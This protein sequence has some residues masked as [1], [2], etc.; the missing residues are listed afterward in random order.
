MDNMISRLVGTAA[1]LDCII[2]VGDLEEEPQGRVKK[3]GFHLRTYK[4]QFFLSSVNYLGFILIQPAAIPISRLVLSSRCPLQ[5]SWVCFIL[6]LVNILLLFLL[7]FFT[8]T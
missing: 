6:F 1:N 8:W 4:C 5:Q 3:Y 7:T 2:V